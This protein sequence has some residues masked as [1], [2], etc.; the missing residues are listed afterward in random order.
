MPDL[1]IFRAVLPE[2]GLLF[3]GIVA[4]AGIFEKSLKR[5]TPC[6]PSITSPPITNCCTA[7]RL[8]MLRTQLVRG[9]YV[10][11]GLTTHMVGIMVNGFKSRNCFNKCFVC[12]IWKPKENIMSI[13]NNSPPFSAT[14]QRNR[15]LVG[16]TNKTTIKSSQDELI[17]GEWIANAY[18]LYKMRYWMKIFINWIFIFVCLGTGGC[19]MTRY[20]DSE[21]GIVALQ[22]TKSIVNG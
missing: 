4:V 7:S 18:F 8:L 11:G 20:R 14:L 17:C 10:L 9:S 16:S 3:H 15:R 13:T 12:P 21:E 6:R 1:A 2:L 22:S 19:D 5:V